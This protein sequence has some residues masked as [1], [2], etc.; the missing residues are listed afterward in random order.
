MTAGKSIAMESAVEDGFVALRTELRTR[1][2]SDALAA[3]D[4]LLGALPDWQRSS[5]FGDLGPEFRRAAHDA[6][7]QLSGAVLSAASCLVVAELAL[8]LGASLGRRRVTPDVLALV[9]AAAARLLAHL[10]RLGDA[11]YAYPEDHFLKDL[12]FAAGMTVPAGAAV[13]D[14]RSKLG[15]RATL[16]T[17]RRQPSISS[18]GALLTHGNL[19]PWFRT[20]TES[21]YLRH[22]HDAGWDAYYGRVASMLAADGGVRGVVGTSWFFDPALMKISPRL[23]YLLKPLAAG[24]FLVRGRTSEFDITSATIASEARKKLYE[25]GRYQPTPYT[26]VWPREALLSWASQRNVKQPTG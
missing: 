21:R 14:L 20:H 4:R 3:A 8:S 26:L 6:Q 10:R 1:L 19:D 13:L 5:K 17:L 24:A 7:A 2:S 9:P 22:F 23:D 15:A 12:R 25:E 16:D 18:F 11:P